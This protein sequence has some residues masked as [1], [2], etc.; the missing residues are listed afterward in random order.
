[1]KQTALL[2]QENHG[3]NYV[4]FVEADQIFKGTVDIVICDGFVGNVALKASEG[5]AKLIQYFIKEAFHKNWLTRL[6]GVLAFPV[7]KILRK[8]IDPARYNGASLL[9]LQG[10]VIK[11]HGGTNVLGFAHAIE[12]AIMEVDKNVPAQIRDQVS[13]LLAQEDVPSS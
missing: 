9:G 12:E 7:L 2:L 11:S 13:H 3:L 8:R 10:I 4:G 1:M 5:A 6:C